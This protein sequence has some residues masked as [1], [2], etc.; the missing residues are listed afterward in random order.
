MPCATST[1]LKTK[2]NDEATFLPPAL[3]VFQGRSHIRTK[4]IDNM[5]AISASSRT[6]LLAASLSL[7]A[8]MCCAP[9]VAQDADTVQAS[10]AATAIQRPLIVAPVNEAQLTILKGNT[11]PLA[12]REFDLG[13]A[14]AT[15]PMQRMLL[16]LKRSPE[17]ESAL[18]K[19]LD[20]Q[21]DKHSPSYHKWLT[22]ESFGQKFGPSDFDIQTISTWLQ[23]HGFQVSPTKGRTVIEFSGSASQVKETFRT[24]IHKYVVNGEQ[25]WANASDPQIPAAL[26][27]AVSGIDSL[28][29]FGRKPM[30]RFLGVVSRER[31]TGK[32]TI[33]HP[34][35]TF[36]VPA[37]NPCN[38]QDTNCYAVGPYDFAAIY[39][40]T[41]LWNVGI[42][43]TG[44]GIAIV[45]NSNINIADAQGF[46]S[47]LACPLMI[48][49]SLSM[50]PT[51]AYWVQ[52]S[53]A[54]KARRTWTWNGQV[55]LR[56]AQ[57][58][59]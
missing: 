13:S 45:Q 35:F 44:Q 39:N 10:S 9:S 37:Q 29:N 58:S 54:P 40:V 6:H 11:H 34:Q 41:P 26:A 21:Q 47:M 32:I 59:T 25:H 57:R 24:A 36:P 17:Q 16:V 56:K 50:G 2:E 15:L 53:S 51:R 55:Q 3:C 20:D 38:A 5:R 28:H 30:S 48:P 23:S 43:G 27:S 8:V 19:L 22:P 42:D 4:G 33:P 7:L 31:A 1:E 46:R 12:R 18:K 14:P 52:A 49:T